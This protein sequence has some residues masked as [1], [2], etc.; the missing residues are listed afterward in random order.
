MSNHRS[1]DFLLLLAY[2]LPVA[3]GPSTEPGPGSGGGEQQADVDAAIAACGDFAAKQAQ[4]YAED[5][6]SGGYP[7]YGYLSVL[8]YCISYLGYAQYVGPACRGAMEDHFACLAEL[9]CDELV[10]EDGFGDAGDTG[11]TGGDEPP[12][13]CAMQSAAVDAAC[14]FSDDS[15]VDFETTG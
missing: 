13:P 10:I 3:C 7:G 14:D 5:V 11:G 4:C 8:G 1:H 12:Q 9:D 6:D 2:G 15:D